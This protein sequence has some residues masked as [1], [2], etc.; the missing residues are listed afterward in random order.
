MAVAAVLVLLGALGAAALDRALTG[1]PVDDPSVQ[2]DPAPARQQLDVL[3]DRLV[4]PGFDL[5]VREVRGERRTNGGLMGG[6]PGTDATARA[7]LWRQ[8]ATPEQV[9]RAAR[10]IDARLTGAGWVPY[11]RAVGVG[12]S[13][14]CRQLSWSAPDGGAR[15][16]LEAAALGAEDGRDPGLELRVRAAAGGGTAPAGPGVPGTDEVD[17]ECLERWVRSDGTS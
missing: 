11:E 15:A 7:E 1:T 16:V 5:R 6:R 12:E 4:F 8:D 3:L 14:S 17:L 13:G 2:L 10:R 9:M